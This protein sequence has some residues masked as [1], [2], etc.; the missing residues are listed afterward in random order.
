MRIMIGPCASAIGTGVV[1]STTSSPS[2]PGFRL[3][4]NV[5]LG[6]EG[7]ASRPRSLGRGGKGARNAGSNDPNSDIVREYHACSSAATLIFDS[8]GRVPRATGFVSFS[9]YTTG[10]L[11]ARYFPNNCEK[12]GPFQGG[13]H[14]TN[15]SD[16]G[17]LLQ[18]PP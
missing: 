17:F 8:R 5:I 9:N 16:L 1:A 14:P 18:V 11:S 7:G 6:R 12:D 3:S 15:H 13:S 10:E 4:L 2:P